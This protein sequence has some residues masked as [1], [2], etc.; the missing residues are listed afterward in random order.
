[1]CL[2]KI[3]RTLTD[4]KNFGHDNSA[5]HQPHYHENQKNDIKCKYIIEY[6]VEINIWSREISYGGVENAGGGEEGLCTFNFVNRQYIFNLFLVFMT[7]GR[8]GGVLLSSPKF[9]LWDD[10]RLNFARDN[11]FLNRMAKSGVWKIGQRELVI[12]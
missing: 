11:T 6:I 2:N 3:N 10:A 12:V 8:W 4:R 1:M 9:V 7:V 5:L